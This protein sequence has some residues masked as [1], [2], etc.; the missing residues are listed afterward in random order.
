[1]E[2]HE[3]EKE[4]FIAMNNAFRKKALPSIRERTYG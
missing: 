1:M 3:N 4:N 2:N